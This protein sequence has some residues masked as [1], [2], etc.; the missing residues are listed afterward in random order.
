LTSEQLE[1][2]SMDTKIVIELIMFFVII[3]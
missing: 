2:I 3:L 1:K